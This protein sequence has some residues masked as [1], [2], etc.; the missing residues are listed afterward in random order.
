MADTRS[1]TREADGCEV[2]RN[3]GEVMLCAAD[4]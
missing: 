3:R 2:A 1:T 4:T